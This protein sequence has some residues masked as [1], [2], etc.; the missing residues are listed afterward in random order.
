[1]HLRKAGVRDLAAILLDKN[2]ARIAKIGQVRADHLYYG[3]KL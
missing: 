1:M 2:P 3:L